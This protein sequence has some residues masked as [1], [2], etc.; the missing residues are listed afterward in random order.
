MRS[1]LATRFVANRRFKSSGDS[2]TI[3]LEA[4][5][6]YDEAVHGHQMEWAS[7]SYHEAAVKRL[8]TRPKRL[9]KKKNMMSTLVT[10]SDKDDSGN[11]VLLF[12]GQGSQFVGM[13]RKI[14]EAVPSAKDLY[15]TASHIL[16]Y[17]LMKLCLGGPI[18][19]LD[20]TSYCQAATLVTSLA[21]VEALYMTSPDLIKKCVASAGFSVGEITA[22]TFS[23][24]LSFEDAVRL[25]RI[26]G[27][28]MEAA[29]DLEP[30]GMMT[31]F[32]GKDA[33]LA[34]ACEAARKWCTDMHRV[35]QPVCQVA[36]YLYTGAKVLAGHNV[37]LDFVDK[38]KS[39]FGIKK[40]KRLP[41][42][43][44]FHTPL[45]N[46]A[47]EAFKEALASTKLVNPRIP[48]YSNN[49]MVVYR[50]AYTIAKT[51]PKQIVKCVKWEQSMNNLFS[52]TRPEYF[53]SVVE[54]GP[55]TGL[56]SILRKVNGKV[57]HK[58][59]AVEV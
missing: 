50:D 43:G 57:A 17:D 3:D 9:K 13:G 46:P 2:K 23:G 37:C 28:A 39:D 38:N 1:S 32:Y 5:A 34:L 22:L 33:N 41:V 42:S 19:T 58:C 44:A 25:I 27:E 29:S 59:V 12:P 24:A 35:D 48:V 52:Y 36:N 47:L 26:R 53:P 18:E 11:S 4:A 55:G 10:P 7:S 14:L 30:S 51:L 31:V 15:G 56:S 40:V 16:G 8:L 20:R 45:M 54:L 6:S 21:G 49:E